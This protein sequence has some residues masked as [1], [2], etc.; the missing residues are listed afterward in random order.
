L[1][2][3]TL[4]ANANKVI[5]LAAGGT[6]GHMFPAEALAGELLARGLKVALLTDKRG[7]AFG[8]RVKG[9]SIHSIS[10]G[11][12]SGGVVQKAEGALRL[13]VGLFQARG[14]LARL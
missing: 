8:E 5:V 13:A 9:V 7:E 14:I 2:A 6:G 3:T 11:V 4:D 10:A 1:S 12:L